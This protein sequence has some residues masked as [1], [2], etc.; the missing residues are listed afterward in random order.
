M[1]G[2]RQSWVGTHLELRVFRPTQADAAAAVDLRG[3]DEPTT[4]VAYDYEEVVEP[5]FLQSLD[6]PV[7]ALVAASRAG[8]DDPPVSLEERRRLDLYPQE[9]VLLL[10]E[11]VAIGAMAE[12]NPYAVTLLHQPRSRDSLADVSLSPWIRLT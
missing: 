7:P 3:R 2:R 9:L 10:R 12:R 11:K 5:G 1:D 6:D 8:S 4:P